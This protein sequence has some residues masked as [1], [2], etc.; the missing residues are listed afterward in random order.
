MAQQVL[1]ILNNNFERIGEIAPA[2]YYDD[3]ITEDLI[4]GSS[5]FTLTINK[6]KC[7]DVTKI[8]DDTHIITRD[9]MGERR[10]FSLFT[11]DYE[12]ENEKTVTYEEWIVSFLQAD[13]PE[14]EEP[15]EVQD[16]G[17]Y[18]QK[19][20]DNTP[21]WITT[22]GSQK[23]KT[24]KLSKQKRAT[25]LQTLYREF[26]VEPVFRTLFSSHTSDSPVG[27]ELETHERR[28]VDTD[29]RLDSEVNLVK[30]TRKSNKDGLITGIKVI[31][32]VSEEEV[33]KEVKVAKQTVGVIGTAS[34]NKTQK[35]IAYLKRQKGGVYTQ[36][37][38][39]NSWSP[40]PVSA[41]CSSMV[42]KSLISAGIQCGFKKGDWLGTT[43]TLRDHTNQGKYFDKVSRKDIQAGDI[44]LCNGWGHVVTY[45]GNNQIFHASQWGVPHGYANANWYLNNANMIIRPKDRGSTTQK[46]PTTV[47]TVVFG[48]SLRDQVWKALKDEG[49][50]DVGASGIMG[51]LYVESGYDPKRKQ[52]GGGPGRGLAQWTNTDRWQDAIRFASQN[53]LDVWTIQA[54]VKF[55][56]HELSRTWESTNMVNNITTYGG[57]KKTTGWESFKTITN[58][59]NA[60][61]AFLRVYE[62][63]GIEHAGRRKNEARDVYNKYKGQ[64][65]ELQA[66]NTKTTYATEKLKEKVKKEY[67]IKEIAYDDGNINTQ[68]GSDEIISRDAQQLYGFNRQSESH[69]L[70]AIHEMTTSDPATEFETALRILEENS[71]PKEE[72]SVDLDLTDEVTREALSTVK[73]GDRIQIVSH[74]WDGT[75]DLILTARVSKRSFSPSDERNV[76]VTLSNFERIHAELPPEI[77]NLQNRIKQVDRDR[78]NNLQVILTASATTF[79]DD[80]QT[81]TINAS[82]SNMGEDYTRNIPG[83]EFYWQYFDKNG[84]PIDE[85][86]ELNIMT[87]NNRTIN[88]D[89]SATY[90]TGNITPGSQYRFHVRTLG[91]LFSFKTIH[92][93]GHQMEHSEVFDGSE[94]ILVTAPIGGSYY[95]VTVFNTKVMQAVQ[96]WTIAEPMATTGKKVV[97]HQDQVQ[98]KMSVTCRVYNSQS[99]LS[100]NRKIQGEQGIP[101]PPGTSS[102]THIAYADNDTGT[103]N[104]STTNP[105]RDYM[106]VY[107]GENSNQPTNPK[108]Y[109]W[110]KIVGPDGEDGVPGPAGKDGRTPYLH[111]AYADSEDG[112]TNFS[113]VQAGYRKFVGRYTDYDPKDSTDPTK[114][115]WQRVQGP[116]GPKGDRGSDGL[117]GK[118]GAG[119]TDTAIV[120]GSSPSYNQQPTSW[121]VSVPRVPKGHYLWTRTTWTY[122]DGQKE[123][124]YTY[125][126]MGTDGNDGKNGIAGKDGVGIKHTVIDYVESG[127]G[128][129]IPTSGWRQNVP[130][131]RDGF[132][133][134]TRTTW[135]YTDNTSE[136]GYSVARMG[137]DGK[138]GQLGRN[139]LIGSNATK[140]ATDYM[141][142]QWDL[143]EEISPDET[144]TITVK[145]EEQLKA[146]RWI[147]L[148][149]GGSMIKETDLTKSKDNPLVYTSTFRWKNKQGNSLPTGNFVRLFHGPSASPNPEI[150]LDWAVMA[151]GDVQALDW[152]QS[153]EEI[154]RELNEKASLEDLNSATESLTVRFAEIPT[155]SDLDQRLEAERKAY[156][157]IVDKAGDSILTDVDFRVTEST[158]NIADRVDEIETVTKKFQVSDEGLTIREKDSG[159]RTVITGRSFNIIDSGKDVAVF[160]NDKA[161]INN[162]KARGVFEFGHHAVT[163]EMIEGKRYTIIRPV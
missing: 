130:T 19:S 115:T 45:M 3:T 10:L 127:N 129:T 46:K 95:E 104:F 49:M 154:Q 60:T 30:A 66:S 12:D 79:S 22:V 56:K 124:G 152:Y 157:E 20:V 147:G 101:G 132:Y 41:D 42:Y 9:E 4:S 64:Y 87:Y 67:S 24:L 161:E 51:N 155:N 15:E 139:L 37:A 106:G 82:V 148:W 146:G 142:T 90:V 81:I 80:Q 57:Q 72:Y 29:V 35:Q 118:D 53:N 123:T 5:I 93:D 54:Q 52:N 7:P 18:L 137:V 59:D 86:P 119:I 140:H 71:R 11:V 70:M 89:G 31:P 63:A 100:I 55:I 91:A 162:L 58:V 143:A 23:K 47:Q 122:T 96:L 6:R 131:V 99:Y 149:F 48:N 125:A 121:T 112:R 69:Y 120:Y 153:Y 98:E 108:V 32:F 97:I 76:K 145:L 134:W 17:Y 117:P 39:R 102:Y 144:I 133:L 27:I 111:T 50:T 151:R 85:V 84:I 36:S 13:T 62:R 16:L 68:S 34:P 33:T 135:H 14:I 109:K 77:V 74:Y 44:I 43:Y 25:R 110:T 83:D 38:G 40:E 21:I 116:Q 138:T 126:Y 160:A 26:G 94:D 158:K 1:A 128:T 28:G 113:T 73:I 163:G 92:E 150:K 114:Y 2:E 103:L 159:M 61:M 8:T 156:Q 136:T 141:V 75:E 65:G 88:A 107:V 78:L 105:R